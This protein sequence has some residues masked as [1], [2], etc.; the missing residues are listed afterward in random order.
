M[1]TLKDFLDSAIY[2]DIIEELGPD[3]FNKE[4]QSIEI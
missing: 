1:K 4:L 3:N 2:L